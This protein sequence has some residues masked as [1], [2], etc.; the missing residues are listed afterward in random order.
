VAEK[1]RHLSQITLIFH[2]TTYVIVALP[3]FAQLPLLGME[4][5]GD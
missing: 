3:Q 1:R 2:A 5:R 4:Y